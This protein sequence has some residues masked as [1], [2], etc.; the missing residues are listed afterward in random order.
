MVFYIFPIFMT[1]AL[2][3]RSLVLINRGNVGDKDRFNA[4]LEKLIKSSH[5]PGLLVFPEGTRNLRPESRPLRK[6][7]LVFAYSRRLPVQ[8]VMTA[9]KE[10]VM[11]SEKRPTAAYGREIWTS[12][13][14]VIQSKDFDSFETFWAKVRCSDLRYS[15]VPGRPR[16]HLSLLCNRCKRSGLP[17]GRGST[18]QTRPLFRSWCRGPRSTTTRPR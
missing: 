16:R 13:A 12:Y 18:R 15:T 6:G 9:R 11:G 3:I 5:V 2:V 1:S 17:S 14:P 4:R 7:M 8:I 10:S